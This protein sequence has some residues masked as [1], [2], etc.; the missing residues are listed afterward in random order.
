MVLVLIVGGTV[1][2]VMVLMGAAGYWLETS[3]DNALLWS[4]AAPVSEI[5][6]KSAALATPISAFAAI[7]ACSASRMSG[8]RSRRDEGSPAGTAGGSG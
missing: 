1:V 3:A 2:I 4:P 6:G 7:N 5:A 8:R